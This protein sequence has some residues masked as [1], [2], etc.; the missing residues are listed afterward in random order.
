MKKIGMISAMLIES[1]K[2]TEWLG[3]PLKIDLYGDF[4]V[5][6]YVKNNAEIYLINSGVG[7]ILASARCQILCSIYKVDFIINFGLCGSLNNLQLSEM[8]V[9][10]RIVHYDFDISA[11]DGIEVGRYSRFDSPLVKTDENLV[12][13]VCLLD[14]NIQKVVCAS[15]DKFVADEKVKENLN[16]TY[17]AEICEMESAGI[18]LIS[19]AN[20]VPALFIKV[21]SDSKSHKEEF[22]AFVERN[23]FN[24]VQILDKITKEV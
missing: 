18:L 1:Q 10:T 17:G 8:C 3:K 11:L 15:A 21:V 23:N 22:N 6:T 2:V 4:K 7:E 14:E 19:I 20:H 12:N 13:F 24:F 16:K 5:E 9:V